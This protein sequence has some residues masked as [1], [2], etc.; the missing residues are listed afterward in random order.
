ME[1]KL[2]N[3]L[4]PR[5]LYERIDWT[6]AGQAIQ[7][8]L[9]QTRRIAIKEQLDK[10]VEQLISITTA[11]TNKL[12]PTTKSCPYSKQWFNPELKEHQAKYNKHRRL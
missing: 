6:R 1:V 11:I 3:T 8:A 5:K 10:A 7:C 9:S 2:A 4:P 12:T